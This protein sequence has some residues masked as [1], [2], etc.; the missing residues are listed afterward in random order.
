VTVTWQVS[1]RGVGGRTGTL[2]LM[3]RQMTFPIAVAERQTVVTVGG[4]P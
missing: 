1:W 2:P 4:T 3:E